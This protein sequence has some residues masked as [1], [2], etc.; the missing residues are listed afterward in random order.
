MHPL[1]IQRD[2]A[3]VACKSATKAKLDAKISGY[4]KTLPAAI[5]AFND[6]SHSLPVLARAMKLK[7]GFL[8]AL[9]YAVIKKTA[10]SAF[11]KPALADA[12]ARLISNGEVPGI[13]VTFV[14]A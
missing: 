14:S 6:T 8:G 5:D 1:R 12:V 9:Y 11:D 2:Q 10:P 4:Q 3:P 13:K 7:V